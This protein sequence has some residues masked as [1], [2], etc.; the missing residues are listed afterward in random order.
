MR[1]R[2]WNRR[3]ALRA[4]G[5]AGALAALA[6][7]LRA[8]AAALAP[9]PFA[10][11]PSPNEQIGIGIIGVGDLGRNHHLRILLERPQDFRVVA[12]ADVDQQHLDEAVARTGG[13]A[14]GYRDYRRLLER[15][16]VDAVFVVTPDHWHALPVV[17]AAEAGKDIYCEKPLSL[18]VEQG[19]AM[20]AAVRRYGRV[21][22]TGSQQRSDW[23]F[24]WACE[25]ARNGR[26]GRIHHVQTALPP[27]PTHPWEPPQPV[28]PHLDWNFWLGPA[29]W[30]EY[31]PLRCHWTFRWFYEYSGGTLTDW[32]AHHNDIAQWGLGTELSGP[33]EVEGDAERP[34]DGLYQV[35]VN[36]DV[37]YLYGNGVTLRCTTR[38]RN[39]VTFFG[40]DGTVFV[41][42]G[43]IEANPPEVLDTPPGAG[44]V[45]LYESDDHHRNFADCV[46]SRRRCIC[47]VEIGHRSVTVCHLGNIAI[48][49]RRKLRWDPD[50]EQIV[51]D[52]EANRLLSRPMRKP[53][54]L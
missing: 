8:A 52:E 41:T 4:L 6:P 37:D 54:A 3:D 34:Q 49:V 47:D 13:K 10:R 30:A 29:Q 44:P 27:A 45:R 32:G 20:A 24:R 5:G 53:W 40:S 26:V 15:R 33:V 1:S 28:P 9:L 51:G 11:R 43:A 17:H 39:G 7:R 46:R 36:Y 21:F 42:R 48:M 16:D 19:R 50:A 25:L 31:H 12:L 22:Q 18:T 14:T 2:S 38:E 35:P 23:R